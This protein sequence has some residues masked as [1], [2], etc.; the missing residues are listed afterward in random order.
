MKKIIT[1]LLITIMIPAFSFAEDLDSLFEEDSIFEE[2][3]LFEKDDDFFSDDSLFEEDESSDNSALSLVDDL[4]TSET[5]I[6]GSYYFN[7][8]SNVEF[9]LEGNIDPSFSSSSNISSNIELNARPTSNT[10]FY[11]DVTIAYPFVK[12]ESKQYTFVDDDDSTYT[13]NIVDKS[14]NLNIDEM[15]YDFIIDDYFIRVGKQ[16]LNMGVGYF[17]SPA[18]LLN[19]STINPL[20]PE[21]DQEGPLAIKVN[22]PINN[23]NLYGYITLPATNKYTPSDISVAAT[24]ETLI[25]NSEYTLSGYYNYDQENDPTKIAATVSSPL[26]TDIDLVAEAVGAYD[27]SDIN[28]EGTLG[29]QILKDLEDLVDTSITIIAQ[30]NYDQDGK[31]SIPLDTTHQAAALISISTPYD[32][33]Y[34]VTSINYLNESS[35]IL[36]G[37]IRYNVSDDISIDFGL[38]YI[39]G[40]KNTLSPSIGFT[41]GQGDF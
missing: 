35:D 2:D 17:Y 20:S 41:L 29:I 10:R 19:I 8:K 32:L 40:L 37:N 18:N 31:N 33:S 22:K 3:S 11:T 6:T 36:N 28:F 34:S 39:Y 25:G 4:L 9:D 14:N 15:F 27:G 7:F 21:D 24:Y 23:N 13:A 12:E 30:Y 1:I 38:N 26:L 5:E 16:T